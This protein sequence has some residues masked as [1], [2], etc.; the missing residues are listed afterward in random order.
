MYKRQLLK[1]HVRRL[2]RIATDDGIRPADIGWLYLSALKLQL[3]ELD[4]AL[5]VSWDGR[6]AS[7]QVL[8]G[9]GDSYV[10]RAAV[11]MTLHWATWDAAKKRL[12]HPGSFTYPGFTT[13]D[14]RLQRID[15]AWMVTSLVPSP[16]GGA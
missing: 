10:V 2:Q 16:N 1:T 4:G 5:P 13:Y 11:Q 6:I 12:V 9:G 8:E 3:R 14:Y 15:G 7:W